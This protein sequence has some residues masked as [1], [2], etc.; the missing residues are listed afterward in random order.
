MCALECASVVSAGRLDLPIECE[1][2]NQGWRPNPV[3]AAGILERYLSRFEGCVQ[4][5]ART[6]CEALEMR[7]RGARGSHL[8][9]TAA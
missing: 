5:L 9:S 7:R 8:H 3:S 6:P 1:V 4:P 2:V